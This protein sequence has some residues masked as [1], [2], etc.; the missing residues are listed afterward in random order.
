MKCY[1][2]CHI[3]RMRNIH[4][5][6][7]RHTLHLWILRFLAKAQYDNVKCF[8]ILRL[9]PQYDKFGHFCHFEQ[10]CAQYDKKK[11]QYDKTRRNDKDFEILHFAMQSFSMTKFIS[12]TRQ[13]NMTI[14]LS[15]TFHK[16]G[17]L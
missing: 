10:S 9:K 16:Y 3:E 1:I 6:I 11:A 17:I 12:L 7:L 8:W 5:E 13:V 15:V 2:L 4:K 14:L